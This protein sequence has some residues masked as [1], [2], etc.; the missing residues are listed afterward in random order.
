MPDIF[1]GSLLPTGQEGRLSR[2]GSSGD[3]PPT[4]CL[5]GRTLGTGQPLPSNPAEEREIRGP[6]PSPRSEAEVCLPGG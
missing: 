6:L 4:V 1:G 2:A 5:E 3:S